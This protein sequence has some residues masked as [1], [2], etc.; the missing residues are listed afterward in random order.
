MMALAHAPAWQACTGSALFDPAIALARDGFLDHAAAARSACPF[1]RHRRPVGR[2][3]RLVLRRRWRAARRSGHAFA[4]PRLADFLADLAARGPDTF[5]VGPNAQAIAS[6]VAHAPVN[7]APMT[8]GD[9]AAYDAKARAPVCGA[10][11]GY[12]IC[13]MGPPS[14]GGTTVFAILKQL[15]R[16]DLARLGPASPVSWHLIAELMRLAY[17]DRDKYLADADHVR[18]P[19]AGLIDPGYLS[20]RSA[21]IATDRTHGDGRRRH[22]GRRAAGRAWPAAALNKAR[23]TSSPPTASATSLR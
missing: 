15:E 5:Y 23:R 22:A 3:A 20:S 10:Y 17:A 11:R 2:G 16:F 14:S 6:T 1:P 12:R 9:L 7:P 19:V 8:A 13:G 18:V 4:I 21:L